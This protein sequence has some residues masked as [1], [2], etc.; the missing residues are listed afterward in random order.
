MVKCVNFYSDLEDIVKERI[1]KFMAGVSFI[2]HYL[3]TSLQEYILQ[4][5]KGVYPFSVQ[6]QADE[7]QPL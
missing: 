1:V 5:L 7:L 2:I 6:I 3:L 4:A